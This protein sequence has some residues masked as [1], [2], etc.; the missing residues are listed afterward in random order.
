MS[1]L[2]T[3]E[4]DILNIRGFFMVG[5]I[6]SKFLSVSVFPILFMLFSGFIFNSSIAE[7]DVLQLNTVDDAYNIAPFAEVLRDSTRKLTFKDIM[8]PSWQREFKPT[9]SQFMHFGMTE[10]VVW[11]RFTLAPSKTRSGATPQ[12]WVLD[13]GARYFYYFW[14]FSPSKFRPG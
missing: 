11:I 6:K 12:E 10:D 14:L 8:E 7:A 13:F 4:S 5:L 9:D 3:V 1:Y 2:H